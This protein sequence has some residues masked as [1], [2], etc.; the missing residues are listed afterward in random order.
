[1]KSINE[2]GIT[3]V[4]LLAAITI[5]AIVI[6]IITAFIYQSNQN[7][8]T[9]TARQAAQEDARLISDH[10]V[11][12]VRSQ[13]YVITQEHPDQGIILNLASG[14]RYVRY[15]YLPDQQR[16]QIESNTT[17][18]EIVRPIADNVTSASVQLTENNKR[19]NLRL[20]F[21]LPGSRHLDYDTTIRVP[22]WLTQS[23]DLN[24]I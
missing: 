11:N 15:R 18:T 20:Q 4:E 19:I 14:S 10:M 8:D 23:P 21:S 24:P 3:L 13:P 5:C 12:Q 16:I 2:K 7:F 17:G 9:I 22:E 1:M 6:R